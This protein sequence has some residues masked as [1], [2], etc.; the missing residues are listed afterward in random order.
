MS[1]SS[2][3]KLKQSR[4]PFA[5]LRSEETTE[6]S[7]L[8]SP[9][10]VKSPSPKT[11]PSRKRKP[12]EGNS[13]N[14][15]SKIGRVNDLKENIE[16]Q[17]DVIE[18]Q[19][20]EE[21]LPAEDVSIKLPKDIE[22]T[23]TTPAPESVFHIKL[24]SCNKSKRKVNMERKPPQSVDEEDPDDSVVYL[25]NEEIQ[26]STKKNKKKSEKKKKKR[27]AP[28][29]DGASRVKKALKLNIDVE[30]VEAVS[31]D[32]SDDEA[33]NDTTSNENLDKLEPMDTDDVP[34]VEKVEEIAKADAKDDEDRI[35]TI[36]STATLEVNEDPDTMHDEII[37]ML[38][39]D[40]GE[41]PSPNNDPD[42]VAGAKFDITKL[43]PK[44]LARRQEQEAR[45]I[46][47]EHQHK[48]ERE[49]KEQQR[50]KE[51]EQR[52]EAKRK[53][54]EEKEEARK[55]EKDEKDRKRQVEKI[56]INFCAIL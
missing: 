17:K 49:L 14:L 30:D 55:R 33:P 24:P 12:S 46:E 1:E 21:E 53:E 18:V 54:K 13:D 26:K 47:K 27:K 5:V 29:T 43:T 6:K 3:K 22:T 2:K 31:V 8:T 19:D 38:S 41:K 50:L 32:G 9:E 10:A 11:T 15:R 44:Q 34:I 16:T 25:S 4:L 23:P 20:S 36:P 42:K 28:S 52:E 40:S 39:D 7:A 56:L 37:D 35:K 48:K 51:K 45:R